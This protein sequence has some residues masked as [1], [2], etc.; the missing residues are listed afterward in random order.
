LV[1]SYVAVLAYVSTL[2]PSAWATKLSAW[3]GLEADEARSL[4][5]LG[6]IDDIDE[7]L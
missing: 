6:N 7:R 5:R 4:R 3:R 2:K 1:L